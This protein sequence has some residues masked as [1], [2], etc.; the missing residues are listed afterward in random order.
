MVN[1]AV[2][3]RYF[4]NRRRVLKQY[5]DQLLR[6]GDNVGLRNTEISYNNY[7]SAGTFLNN[8]SIGNYSYTGINTQIHNAQI[9]KFC[10]IADNVKIGMGFH[11]VDRVS[12]HPSFY[13]NNKAFKCFAKEMMFNEFKET[14]IGNDVWIGSHVMIF[15]GVKIGDGAIIA[16]GSILTKDVEPYTIVGGN[17]AKP[18]RPRFE[19]EVINKLLDFKWWDKDLAWIEANYKAFNVVDDF[20]KII[21]KG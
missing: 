18:I 19:Q 3:S 8:V 14:I 2:N 11:P 20:L 16:G 4:F 5:R 17:P 10:S 12:T 6:M 7:F 9:G 21:K 13:A 1:L 15:G